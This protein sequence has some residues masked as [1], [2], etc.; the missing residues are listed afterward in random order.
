MVFELNLGMDCFDEK[1]H[2]F[3]WRMMMLAIEERAFLSKVLV[4]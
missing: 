4:P 3:G 2:V 1:V